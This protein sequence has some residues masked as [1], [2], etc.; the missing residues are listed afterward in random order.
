M[1][2]GVMSMADQTVSNEVPYSS[3][4]DAV[5]KDIAQFLQPNWRDLMEAKNS[6]SQAVQ[7]Q[8]H[9]RIAKLSPEIAEYFMKGD[10]VGVEDYVN[11]IT[12]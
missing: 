7:D 6:L 9:N 10:K 12:E 1:P 3:G 5:Q 4:V 2:E 11:D 8:L